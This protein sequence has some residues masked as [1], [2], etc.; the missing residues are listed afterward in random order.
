M[1]YWH[2]NQS[3]LSDE[4]EERDMTT[5]AQEREFAAGLRRGLESESK[6]FGC[7]KLFKG[8]ELYHHMCPACHAKEFGYELESPAER[9]TENA[10]Y[11]I[12][13]LEK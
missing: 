6:C 11:V 2:C 7:K 3:R 12:R 13:E 10:E 1:V 5:R 4:A 8:R 9:R